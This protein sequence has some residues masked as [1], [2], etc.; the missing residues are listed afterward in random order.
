MLD[1]EIRVRGQIDPHWS[2]WL[3]G[4]AITHLAEGQALLS[5]QVIDQAALYGLLARLWN[6][7]LPLLSVAVADQPPE[8]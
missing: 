5:G 6:L 2:E 8:A 3:E 7:R 4:L 1:I